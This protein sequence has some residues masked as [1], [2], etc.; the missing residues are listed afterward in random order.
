MIIEG[1]RQAGALMRFFDRPRRSGVRAA[2]RTA[3]SRAAYSRLSSPPSLP[4][5]VTA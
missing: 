4:R 3:S 5:F 1:S 2:T